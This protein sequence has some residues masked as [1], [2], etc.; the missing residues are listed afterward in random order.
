M[1]TR[2]KIEKSDSEL[3]R[4]EENSSE[5]DSRHGVLDDFK[6]LFK[7]AKVSEEVL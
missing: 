7:S 2:E 6:I 5:T 1:E 4:R 3:A